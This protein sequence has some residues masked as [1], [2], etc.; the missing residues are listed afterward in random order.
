MSNVIDY[1]N[2]NEKSP[3]QDITEG[4]QIYQ[5]ATSVSFNTGEWRTNT[6]VLDTDK[7]TQ[8]L[9]CTPVCPDSSIPV[10][11]K[12]RQDFDYD[13]CKGC[14]ICAAVCPFNAITMREGQ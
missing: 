14:G 12:K 1:K 4:N 11:D 9:L 5:A 3:W 7:C 2:I 6:P 13:H 8:C 10:V